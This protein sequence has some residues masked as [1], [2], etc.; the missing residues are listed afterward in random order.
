MEDSK[1]KQIRRDLARAKFYVEQMNNADSKLRKYYYGIQAIVFGAI[2]KVRYQKQIEE[3]QRD[4]F[5]D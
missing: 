3:L 2:V 4:G 5:I 1:I